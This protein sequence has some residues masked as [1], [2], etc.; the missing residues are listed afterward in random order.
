MRSGKAELATAFETDSMNYKILYSVLKTE[1]TEASSMISQA[2]SHYT[3]LQKGSFAE[4]VESW[5]HSASALL[6]S[7]CQNVQ[8]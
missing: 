4:F 6:A 1:I 7:S 2:K 3:P 5:S 8:N